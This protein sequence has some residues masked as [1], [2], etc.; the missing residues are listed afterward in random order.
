[1]K[2]AQIITF[3]E[4]VATTINKLGNDNILLVSVF[5]EGCSVRALIIYKV[6][7]DNDAV[8]V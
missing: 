2:V 3:V 4:D 6:E 1:M 5:Y 7:D 8:R